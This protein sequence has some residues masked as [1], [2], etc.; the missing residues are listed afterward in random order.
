VPDAS[1]D[2]FNDDGVTDSERP[3]GMATGGV[4]VVGLGWAAIARK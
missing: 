3:P 1:C 2:S 4:V